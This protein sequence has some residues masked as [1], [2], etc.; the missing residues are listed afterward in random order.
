MAHRHSSHQDPWVQLAINVGLTAVAH[1]MGYVKTLIQI[2]YEPLPPQLGRNAFF[3]KTLLLPGVAA[4]SKHIWK[5]DGFLGLYRGFVPRLCGTLSGSAVANRVSEKMDEFFPVTDQKD[6]EA[7]NNKSKGTAKISNATF[8]Q[9][10]CK[11]T[12]SHSCAV[13]VTHPFHVIAV[14]SMVQFIG[15]ESKYS[16][17]ISPYSEVYSES[18]IKGFFVGL[19]PRL[20]QDVLTLWLARTLYQMFNSLLLHDKMSNISELRSYAHAIT[21]FI[22]GIVTYPLGL[23][24]NIMAVNNSGL[25]AGSL[26]FMPV[27]SNWI[28]CWVDLRGKG[29]LKRGSSILFRKYEPSKMTMST[30]PLTPLD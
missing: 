22:A 29:L 23:V 30:M 20:L 9:E 14:R 15:R 17:W 19:V 10:T 21:G 13:I 12:V 16:G 8:I 27:Y 4:Y 5:V 24:S 18:G 1:P 25:A 6:L 26:P 11:L 2:G 3:R 7:M 28:G